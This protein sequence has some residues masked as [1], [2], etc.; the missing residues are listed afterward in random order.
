MQKAVTKANATAAAAEA[1][2][3]HAEALRQQDDRVSRAQLEQI[4]KS[5]AGHRAR[6]LK[7][8]TDLAAAQQ[9]LQAL[10]SAHSDELKAKAAAYAKVNSMLEGEQCDRAEACAEL[11]KLKGERA[12]MLK[13]KQCSCSRSDSISSSTDV[14]ATAVVAIASSCQLALH[15]GTLYHLER[16]RAHAA[17]EAEKTDYRNFAKMT[18]STTN[19]LKALMQLKDHYIALLEPYVPAAGRQAL[20]AQATAASEAAAA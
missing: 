17:V 18:L 3:L 11:K 1:A 20:Y 12:A 15:A 16:C 10:R 19:D 7:A 8:E 13:C 2:A 5:Y 4:Q 9:E 14:V 6:A